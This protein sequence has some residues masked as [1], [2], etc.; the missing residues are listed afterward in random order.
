MKELS[1]AGCHEREGTVRALGRYGGAGHS[2]TAREER[3]GTF[4]LQNELRCPYYKI[5]DNQGGTVDEHPPLTYVR[6]VFLLFMYCTE[7][8]GLL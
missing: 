1:A 6:G 7:I 4:P 3:D 2:G 5:R 8:G